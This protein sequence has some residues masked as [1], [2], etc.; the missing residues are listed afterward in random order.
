MRIFKSK[1]EKPS[2]LDP[3]IEDVIA[4][5]A[6]YEATDEE[7]KKLLSVLRD[8]IEAKAAEPKP[9]EISPDVLA[10][11]AGNLIGVALVLLFETKGVINSRALNLI[12]KPKT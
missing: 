8:L 3:L 9:K 7:Y 1:E 11:V 2:P 5:M 4:S 6:G 12:P 10:A